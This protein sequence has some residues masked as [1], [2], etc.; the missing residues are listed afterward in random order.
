MYE[1]K[2]NIEAFPFSLYKVIKDT[3]KL[4]VLEA[5]KKQVELVNIVNKDIP[6]LLI[7]DPCRIKQILINL[8]S[9]AIKFSDSGSIDVSSSCA[10]LERQD[11]FLVTIKVKDNGQGISEDEQQLLFHPF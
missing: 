8:L 2:L 4:V 9:N 1:N 5:R 6:P 7:G 10:P 3:F 11:Q